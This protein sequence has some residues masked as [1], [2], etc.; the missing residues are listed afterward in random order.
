MTTGML[1]MAKTVKLDGSVVAITGGA[2]GI[3]LATA[4]AFAQQGAKLVI[5]DID[6]EL[7]NREAQALGGHGFEIDVRDS[8]SMKAFVENTQ[9]LFGPIDVFIN[10]AGIMPTGAFLEE[11]AA[12]SD[13]QI[14]INLRGVI[15]GCQAVLP[16]MKKRGAGHILNIASMAGVLPIPGLAVYCATKFAVIGLTQS[17]REE[18]RDSGIGFS[19]I[20]PAKVTTELASGSDEAAKRMPSSSPEQVAT[21]IVTAVL[22]NQTEI[23]VPRYLGVTPTLLNVAPKGLLQTMRKVVGDRGVLDKLDA[24]ARSGYESRLKRLTNN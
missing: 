7:A 6:G 5:G 13:T 8:A 20:M 10:N 14:D 9:Q 22:R 11:S 1:T 12:V 15:H 16:T 17:L 19:T 21:A 24:K 23:T 18:F 4:K 3:G 2:R